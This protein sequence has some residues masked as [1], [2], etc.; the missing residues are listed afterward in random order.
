MIFKKKEG[1]NHKLQFENINPLRLPKEKKVKLLE[2]I[3]AL[4]KNAWGNFE[5]I[6]LYAY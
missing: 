1:N 3:D 6:F 2:E 5:I 4:L